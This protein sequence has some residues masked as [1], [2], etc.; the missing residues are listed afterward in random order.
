MEKVHHY[1]EQ[2]QSTSP[3]RSWTPGIAEC[4]LIRKSDVHNKMCN[5]K[6]I[7][8][9]ISLVEIF[10]KHNLENDHHK[11]SISPFN[12]DYYRTTNEEL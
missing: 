4:Q 7:Y 11:K 5:F 1:I 12:K 10:K 2:D 9:D 6:V 3:I 8:Q